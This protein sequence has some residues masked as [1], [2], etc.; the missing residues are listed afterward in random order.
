MT[1]ELQHAPRTERPT[2]ANE[3][4][5]VRMCRRALLSRFDKLKHGEIRLV[6]NNHVHTFGRV[7]S[8]CSL[9]VEVVVHRPQF[10]Q[11]ATLGGDV[12]AAESFMDGDW[13]CDDL[14]SLIRILIA[15]AQSA[16]ARPSRMAWLVEPF[17][18]L[19]HWLNRNTRSGSRRNIAAHYDL[20][21]DFFELFLDETRM[22]SCGVFERPDSTL[23]EAS[24]AKN[25]RICR[26]LQLSPD[27]HLLEI[28][29]GWGGFAIHAAS[30]FGCRI[31]TTTIS[32]EQYEFA[33]KRIA[34]AGLSDRITVLFQDYRDLTGQYDKL[35]SIEMIEAV[36]D[37]FLNQYFATCGQLL[38]PNG[39]MALQ[40]ITI[41]DQLYD[42]Y[43]R[44]VD[45]IQK[46][47]F[48]GGCLPSVTRICDAITRASD[49]RL[50]H[51]EDLA[52]H[53]AR[54]LQCW[55]D[56]FRERLSDVKRLGFDDR[57][58]RMWEYYLSYCEGAFLE[59]NCGLVQMVFTKPLCRREPIVPVID[60]V[61]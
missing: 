45:F 55:R 38:K 9:C 40:G 27:D 16:A 29:T 46:Y 11:R 50:F 41:A 3:S 39:L 49:L 1:S 61:G 25:E 59:R 21:N 28:G 35:V 13:T 19:G 15:N 20:G 23:Y 5:L 56:R 47:I 54:T 32:R 12:G 22:Y 33:V 31:T 60:S 48:P 2:P 42:G 58:I 53:Y 52:P 43:I 6:E 51:L 57:F 17:R 14:A 36:G 10:Y 44:R 24:T 30:R 7:S 8:T 34:D 18:R 4:R 37:E 26:K